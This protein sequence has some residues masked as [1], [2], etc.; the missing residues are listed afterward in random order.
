MKYL[1]LVL[2][3]AAALAAKL[4]LDSSEAH[5]R[6]DGIL[7]PRLVADLNEFALGHGSIEDRGHFDKLDKQDGY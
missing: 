5:K 7:Y 6:A 4:P 1:L 3:V 2:I